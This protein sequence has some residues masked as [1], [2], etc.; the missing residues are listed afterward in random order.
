VLNAL[1]LDVGDDDDGDDEFVDWI[2]RPDDEV[3]YRR[4]TRDIVLL[5]SY[6][7]LQADIPNQTAFTVRSEQTTFSVR[8]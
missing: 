6:S 3:L 7:R 2:S 4:G 1:L 8:L 5:R